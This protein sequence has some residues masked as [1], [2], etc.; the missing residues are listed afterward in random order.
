MANLIDKYIYE[1]TR[2]LPEKDREDVKKE[3]AANI[4]DMLS[5]NPGEVEVKTVLQSLGSPA[6]L[7]EQYRQTPRY[8]I[9]P[10]FFDSYVRTLKWVV[11]LVGCILL[12]LGGITGLIKAL[13]GDAA[14]P[15][16]IGRIIGESI[17]MGI[18]GAFQA[19]VWVT[20]GFAIADRAGTKAGMFNSRW[21]VESLDD[22]VI[23]DKKKISLAES[24]VELVLTLVFSILFILF[25][26]GHLPFVL[27][28][29]DG[30]TIITQL[31]SQSFVSVLIPC[32]LISMLFEIL[33]IVAK[34]VK[35]RYTPLVCG[36]IIV[37]NLVT[38]G[39][40]LLCL[41]RPVIFHADLLQYIEGQGWLTN[42]ALQF[43]G[44]SV[45]LHEAVVIIFGTIIAIAS[46]CSIVVTI[47]R[48]VLENK[49]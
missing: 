49:G 13:Q 2:R 9:S 38:I 28:I 46:I 16:F 45:S 17:G 23:D 6:A 22:V 43:M 19:L 21:S 7:A 34:I 42:G 8:L 41:T 25:C 10:A 5:D 18:S 36:A 27:V 12:I 29:K 40:A 11:P 26:L 31:F 44:N 14:V 20:I 48:T 24:I 4:Y 35:R 37:N 47:Y 15:N 3:L 39:L 33:A 30:N 1:V 32:L